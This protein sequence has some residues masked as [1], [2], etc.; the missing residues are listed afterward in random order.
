[1]PDALATLPAMHRHALQFAVHGHPGYLEVAGMLE[2]SSP[3][4]ILPPTRVPDS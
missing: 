3:I 1:L 2:A 4:V